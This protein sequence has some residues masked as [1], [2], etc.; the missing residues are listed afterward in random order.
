MVMSPTRSPFDEES[1]GSGMCRWVS[2]IQVRPVVDG[3]MEGLP[4]TG[5]GDPDSGL[6]QVPCF[7]RSDKRAQ[8]LCVDIDDV[9]DLQ[10][11]H[12]SRLEK[13]WRR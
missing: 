11:S 2:V 8:R 6:Y 12:A 9:D 1:P 13:P 7:V 10:R 3:T 4:P 5:L